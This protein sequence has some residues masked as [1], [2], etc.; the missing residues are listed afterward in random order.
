[1]NDNA[2]LQQ[3]YRGVFDSQVGFGRAPAIIVVDLIHA[4]TQPG[5]LGA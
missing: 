1:M 5:S 2:E 4:Y 3:N